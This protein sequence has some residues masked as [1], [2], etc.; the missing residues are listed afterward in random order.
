MSNLFY[1]CGHGILVDDVVTSFSYVV[2]DKYL[3]NSV[4]TII[5][6]VCLIF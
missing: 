6:K 3:F 4:N 5:L 2:S 1:P